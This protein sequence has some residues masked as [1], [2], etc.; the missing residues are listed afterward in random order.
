MKL[1]M[2]EEGSMMGPQKLQSIMEED[3]LTASYWDRDTTQDDNESGNEKTML[4]RIL[5]Y[6]DV[7]SLQ[8][9][10]SSEG[11]QQDGKVKERDSRML[12]K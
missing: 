10:E 4:D 7:D 6:L 3:S 9:L 1:E 8:Y 12:M 11:K 2:V 5:I